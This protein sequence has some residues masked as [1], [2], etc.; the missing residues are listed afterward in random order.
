VGVG[1]RSRDIIFDRSKRRFEV[2]DPRKIYFPVRAVD[3]MPAWHASAW[4]EMRPA[5]GFGR[6]M[7]EA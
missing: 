4:S 3:S 1:W 7:V 2:I 6:W 5:V